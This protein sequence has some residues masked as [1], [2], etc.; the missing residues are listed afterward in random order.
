MNGTYET[1][2]ITSDNILR[3]E[4]ELG[5]NASITPYGALEQCM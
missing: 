4:F 5:K 3:K 1:Y 2:S